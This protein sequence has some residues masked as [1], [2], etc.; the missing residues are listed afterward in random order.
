[1]VADGIG[2]QITYGKGSG[3][4]YELSGLR[5]PA[6]YAR[7]SSPISRL[8]SSSLFMVVFLVD[9]VFSLLELLNCPKNGV[10]R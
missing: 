3:T 1:M 7:A 6:V 10:F 8:V 9:H 5:I 4:E 2:I